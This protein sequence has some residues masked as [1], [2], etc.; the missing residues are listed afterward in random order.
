MDNNDFQNLLDTYWATIM[1]VKKNYG[2][3]STK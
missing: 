2:I 3:I 1:Y